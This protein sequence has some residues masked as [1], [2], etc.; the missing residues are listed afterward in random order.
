MFENLTR[1][2]IESESLAW[3]AR[4]VLRDKDGHPHLWLRIRMTGTHFPHRASEPYLQVGK[5]R[6]AFA[7]IEPDG[8]SVSG[9][10]D[11]PVGGGPVEFGYEGDGPLLRSARPLD[12]PATATLDRNLL[13]REVRNLDRFPAEGPR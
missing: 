8:L 2:P 11:R 13:P 12:V 10:F 7:I 9:Y 5:V 3:E 4:E 1:F 6:S